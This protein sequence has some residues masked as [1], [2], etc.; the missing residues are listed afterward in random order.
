MTLNIGSD[1]TQ[2]TTRLTKPYHALL[3]RVIWVIF[4]ILLAYF[5]MIAMR[6]FVDKLSTTLPLTIPSSNLLFTLSEMGI[7]ATISRSILIAWTWLVIVLGYISSAFIVWKRGDDWVA[8]GTAI[9]LLYV[10]RIALVYEYGAPPADYIPS[11]VSAIYITILLVFPNGQLKPRWSLFIPVWGF[12]AELPLELMI[13]D[14]SGSAE[15]IRTAYPIP[16]ILVLI[17]RHRRILVTEAKQQ[18]KWLFVLI[19]VLALGQVLYSLPE[20]ISPDETWLIG[21]IMRGT[22]ETLYYIGAT[23]APIAILFAMLR[24]RLWDID[25]FIN[26]TLVYGTVAMLVMILFFTVSTGSQMAFG[27]TSP[28]FAFFVSAALSVGFFRPVR[29]QTQHLIDRYIYGLR[30]DLNEL[31]DYETL[32]TIVNPGELTGRQLGDYE[33]QGVIGR[34]GMGE[35][36]EGFGKGQRVAIKTMLAK[37]A[38]DPDFRSRFEREAEAS[39]NLQHPNIVRGLGSGEINDIPYLIMEYIEGD[40]LSR[41]IK[42]GG[43]FTIETCCLIM[44]EICSALSATH[45]AGYVHRDVKPANILI[46]NDGRA[47]LMDFGISKAQDAREITGTEAIGSIHYMA[48]EQIKSSRDVDHHAD[49]Y[50]LGCLFYSMLTGMTPFSGTSVQVMFAQ[51]NKPAPDPRDS[52][53]GIPDY[54]AE[55]ILKAMEKDPQD[56]FSS[57]EEFAEAVGA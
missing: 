40:E 4:A 9:G 12:I 13:G 15:F 11:V 43:L 37:V 41:L 47:M 57:A 39:E 49:I 24:Y 26:R 42:G 3:I 31:E 46:R 51:I 7:P 19:F 23:T 38:H 5:Y 30:F 18:S 35:V 50:A 33:V 55:A 52:Q 34:G 56:R 45:H 21:N 16:L 1:M 32:P 28:L 29:N 2:T 22:G 36:Y 8:V 27:N 54:I 44:S 14:L 20:I 17:Y 10:G 25:L 48:P 6:Q 53:P